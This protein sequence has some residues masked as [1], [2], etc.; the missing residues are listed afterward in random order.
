V[1]VYVYVCACVHVYVR[2]CICVFVWVCV[3]VY[4]CVCVCMRMC[5]CVFSRG[6]DTR[7][8]IDEDGGGLEEEAEKGI[9]G[10]KECG[11]CSRGTC[12]LYHNIDS[13]LTHGWV[14]GCGCV[15]V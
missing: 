8:E 4:V 10:E 13:E 2:V 14:G 3:C 5:M 9:R 6:R 11:S 7:H 12:Q 15:S 1:C